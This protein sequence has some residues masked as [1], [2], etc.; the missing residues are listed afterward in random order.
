MQLKRRICLARLLAFILTVASIVFLAREINDFSV[1]SVGLAVSTVAFDFFCYLLFLAIF[2][3]DREMTKYVNDCKQQH[4]IYRKQRANIRAMKDDDNPN[5]IKR[6]KRIRQ[7]LHRAKNILLL[8]VLSSPILICI[9]GCV[10]GFRDA[11]SCDMGML[12]VIIG[13]ISS[14]Q[15]YPPLVK[16]YLELKRNG[17][18]D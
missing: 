17:E 13:A 15:L 3:G 16:S 12:L 4:K 6:R 5:R 7:A 1:R 18:L 2:L 11:E 9:I 14:S 8:L 10:I